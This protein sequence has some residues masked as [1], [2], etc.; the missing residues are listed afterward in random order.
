[1]ER[2]LSMEYAKRFEY[3]FQSHS[4]IYCARLQIF[5]ATGC[6]HLLEG[7]CLCQLLL[8]HKLR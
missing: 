6:V 5:E 1:M 4:F 3:T 7:S 2:I 8:S